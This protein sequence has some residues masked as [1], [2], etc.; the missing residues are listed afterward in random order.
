[1]LD[2]VENFHAEIEE[3]DA[4]FFEEASDAWS[5]NASGELEEMLRDLMKTEEALLRSALRSE[6]ASM[7]RDLNEQNGWNR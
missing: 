5:K 4:A 1:M 2:H 3:I 6:N 7:A